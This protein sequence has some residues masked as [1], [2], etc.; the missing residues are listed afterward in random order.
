MRLSAAEQYAELG[1]LPGMTVGRRRLVLVGLDI[2]GALG[3]STRVSARRSETNALWKDEDGCGG[4]SVASW[5]SESGAEHILG[6]VQIRLPDAVGG[7]GLF[8]PGAAEL[9]WRHQGQR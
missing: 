7:D 5:S 4:R 1:I 3:D 6:R 8:T 9:A 2:I